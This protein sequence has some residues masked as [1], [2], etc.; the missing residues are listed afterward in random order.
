MPIGRGSEDLGCTSRAV[1]WQLLYSKWRS[2]GHCSGSLAR[3][4]LRADKRS[5]GSIEGEADAGQSP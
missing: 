3:S 2:Q 1:L 4:Q 5:S